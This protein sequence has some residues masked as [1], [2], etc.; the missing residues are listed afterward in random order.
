GVV[1]AL[2]LPGQQSPR[3]WPPVEE[4]ADAPS[5]SP[6]TVRL[7]HLPPVGG[8]AEHREAGPA[9]VVHHQQGLGGGDGYVAV[10]HHGARLEDVRAPGL[11]EPLV[12]PASHHLDDLVMTVHHAGVD[13]IYAVVGPH[14]RDRV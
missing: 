5:T 2:S 14:L 13:V 4:A 9:F 12:H 7:D 11:H 3:R 8:G 1:E 10:D 6:P